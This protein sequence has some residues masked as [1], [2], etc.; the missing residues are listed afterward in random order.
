M[1]GQI[2][3]QTQVPPRA[4]IVLAPNVNR[5]YYLADIK[6]ARQLQQFER[7][8]RQFVLPTTPDGRPD[9]Q[10]AQQHQRQVV[11][12]VRQATNAE[13]R[14][15]QETFQQLVN[16]FTTESAGQIY[17]RNRNLV[18]NSEHNLIHGMTILSST[19]MEADYMNTLSL[20]RDGK[21]LFSQEDLLALGVAGL[22]HD[23]M[24]KGDVLESVIGIKKHM[25][26]AADL[27]PSLIEQHFG[28]LKDQVP[29]FGQFKKTVSLLC[30]Y[31]GGEFGDPKGDEVPNISNLVELIR[32]ADN[33]S[34]TR[35]VYSP[36]FASKRGSGVIIATRVHH[37]NSGT[38]NPELSKHKK[39]FMNLTTLLD[40]V[41]RD[42]L[43]GDY[44][45]ENQKQVFGQ[46]LQDLDLFQTSS[47]AAV[48][49]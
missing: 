14:I 28:F 44:G 6:T 25:Q 11:T 1:E 20:A 9:E 8:F 46:M 43:H 18:H 23:V 5:K 13:L 32:F 49:A 3:E 19:W 7:S 39:E 31:H 33:N 21:P 37:Y 17:Q 34:L 38:Q 10:L 47:S 40:E 4:D 30:L 29:D 12:E 42:R 27:A 35:L 48:A 22:L 36:N 41:A 2:R 24:R 26:L 15:S 45:V 16:V